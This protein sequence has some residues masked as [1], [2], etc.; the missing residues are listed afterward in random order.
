M[1][2]LPSDAADVLESIAQLPSYLRATLSPDGDRLAYYYDG[3]GRYELYVHDIATGE[4]HRLTD[5]E[6]P[7]DPYEP[8]R[9]G[10]AGNRVYVHR[11][12]HESDIYQ[13]HLEDHQIE[14]VITSDERNTLWD[15]S[16]D[17]HSLLYSRSGE[18]CDRRLCRYDRTRDAHCQITEPDEFVFARG[19][20]FDPNGDRMV[21]AATR[22][23]EEADISE[24]TV[25]IAASDGS[26]RRT[27]SVGRDGVRTF[28]KAWGPQGRRLLVYET[29]GQGRSGVY[30]L[31]TGETEWYGDVRQGEKP[32]TFLPDGNRFLAI[33]KDRVDTI[34]VVYTLDGER[35]E[36]DFDGAVSLDPTSSWDIVL[37]T[38]TVLLPRSTTT[39]KGRLLRYDVASDRSR[40]IARVDYGEVD[41]S[42]FVEASY[43]TYESFDRLEI[44]G[45]LYEPPGSEDGA[46]AIVL[47]HGGPHDRAARTFD[48]RAQVLVRL[49]YTVFLPNYRGS[50]GRGTDFK[51]RVYADIGGGE[52]KDLA[53]AGRWLRDRPRVDPDR[54]GIFGHSYGG[55]L[56]AL[57]M[58]TNPTLWAAGIASDGLMDLV[59]AYD[60]HPDVPGLHEMGDPEEDPDLLRERSPISHV[61]ALAHPLLVLHGVRDAAC[62]VEQARAFRAELLASG[63]TDGD[64]FEY[65]ELDERHGVMDVDRKIKRWEQVLDFVDRHL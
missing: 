29:Y 4:R 49:G 22:L 31:Q 40:P 48:W 6:L 64:E 15:V 60:G 57:Q 12:G 3:T 42:S 47:V 36:L 28:G 11:N 1:S 54:I 55:Y 8:I 52:S 24:C 30:D 9:W 20:E 21:F 32:V 56:T 5:G 14:P 63:Y 61:N 16:P 13:I 33:Q 18:G 43:E 65:Y 2:S 34:P 23:A 27:L 17:G 51:R 35:R 62:P 44:G 45:L 37:G 58:V 39:E 46:P 26:N 50:T 19:N 25:H 41:Q 10:P 59:D 38:N 7:R 53:A